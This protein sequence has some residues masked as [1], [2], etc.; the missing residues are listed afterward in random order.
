MV[1]PRLTTMAVCKV[2]K[3]S[4][5]R[6]NVHIASGTFTCAPPN[7]PGRSRYFMP[8]DMTALRLFRNVL[9]D[10]LNVR[11]AGHIA[12]EVS[13]AARQNPRADQI[14]FVFDWFSPPSGYACPVS[15]VPADWETPTGH[16]TDVRQVW[17]LNISKLRK[18]IAHYTEI[19]RPIISP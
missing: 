4:R 15:D 16:D 9:E 8:K 14:S 12:C 19:E 18:L 10:G 3:L 5:D 7:V 11:V 13:K 6:F 2:V 1:E 17:T